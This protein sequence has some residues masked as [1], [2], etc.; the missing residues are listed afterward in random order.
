MGLPSGP[1]GLVAWKLICE[2][3]FVFS[4]YSTKYL[5]YLAILAWCRHSDLVMSRNSQKDQPENKYVLEILKLSLNMNRFTLHTTAQFF[6]PHSIFISLQSTSQVGT[7]QHIN[8]YTPSIDSFFFILSFSLKVQHSSST[9][10]QYVV[11][12]FYK[13][14]IISKYFL[15]HFS[16]SVRKF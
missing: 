6:F 5:N 7:Q 3:S 11:I 4:L 1:R 12:C 14:H 13:G 2:I 10:V 16:N 15:V 9:I 8:K